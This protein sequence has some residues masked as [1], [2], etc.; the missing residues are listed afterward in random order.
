MADLDRMV[1]GLR[2]QEVLERLSEYLD[3]EL[4]APEVARVEAHVR[5]C[6]WCERFGGQFAESVALL[7]RELGAPEPLETARAQRLHQAI[8][9]GMD[10]PV[11]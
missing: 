3:G 9:K 1:A 11:L 5:G 2:C 8:R 4:S 6:D 7:K 10:G